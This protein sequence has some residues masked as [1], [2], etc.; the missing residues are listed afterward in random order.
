[1]FNVGIASGAWLGGRA[2][3]LGGIT[4]VA[5]VSGTLVA[6][7]LPLADRHSAGGIAGD[8]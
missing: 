1:M 6:L 5:L 2:L 8:S 3:D 7:T 4:A